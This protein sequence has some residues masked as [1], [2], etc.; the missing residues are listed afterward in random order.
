VS[1]ESANIFLPRKRDYSAP[2]IDGDFF[3]IGNLL[4]DSEGAIVKRV[5]DFMEYP[6]SMILG[7]T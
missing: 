4:N 7:R 6:L 3:R 5:R 2:P 1:D